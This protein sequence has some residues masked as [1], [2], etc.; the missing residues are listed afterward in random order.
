M[1]NYE[2]I[3]EALHNDTLD[4]VTPSDIIDVL[5]DADDLYYNGEESFLTDSEYDALYRYAERVVPH[6]VYFTGIGSE[7]RGGKIK[8]PYPM[9][10]LDQVYE[11]EIVD[12]V[13]GKNLLNRDHII[14]DKLDGNSA[15]LVFGTNGSIQIGY[16]RGDGIEGA[17]ITRHVRQ[18][19]SIPSNVGRQ[20]VVRGEMIIEKARF[21]EM[22]TIAL[23][24]AGRP[25]KN[26]RN[27][28]A[29]IMNAKT[30]NA[31]VYS[32]IDF[33]AY[34]IV[35]MDGILDKVEQLEQLEKLGFKVPFFSEVRGYDLT[36]SFLTS[37][38]TKR[39]DGN[40]YEIDGIVIDVN[41]AVGRKM[42]NP[43]RDTLNPAYA[44]K[45][46]I[47]DEN[48]QAVATVVNVEWN[49]S[50][51]CYL[52]P[53]VEI[54]PVE[55]VGVT[56]RHATGF[57]AKFIVDNCIGP[58]AKVLI[59]RSGDVIPF[60]QKVVEPAAEP[61]MPTVECSWNETR[62]DLVADEET[63]D[64]RINRLIDFFT[65]LDVPMLRE[66]N[67]RML[68]EAGYT[69]TESIIRMSRHELDNLIGSNGKKIYDGLRE[70][71][72]NVPR[73]VLMGSTHF[74]GRGVG[75]RKFKKLLQSIK[76]VTPNTVH[77]ITSVEGFDEKTAKKIAAGV[78]SFNNWFDMVKDYV[79]IS[80][81]E[82]TNDG[83]SLSGEKVVFTGFRDKDLEAAVEAAGGMIQSGVSSKT[84]I[85]V[86]VDPDSN[87]GKIKKARDL[88]IKIM[89]V[90]EFKELV[91]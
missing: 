12:W 29:G 83:G 16:S 91:K 32:F 79:T 42:L 70:K 43:T 45:Y 24:R 21:P 56:I 76:D 11:G 61:Q 2:A 39:R 82:V 18:I 72:T 19:P 64:I 73:Y 4:Q 74:F 23:N 59:T 58:G 77:L 17:D 47:A 25:Y 27:A 57:N 88:G 22:Q 44:V 3:V 40:I 13:A 37:Y 1:S 50:K 46:K 33:V 9:G 87:S 7:V 90:D 54:E 52:K 28:V 38:L 67:I 5:I 75:K 36:D 34:E 85:V 53:R 66:G 89:G 69:T 26:P 35:G 51:D 14:T 15:L 20:L 68:Y 8:L 84:T 63:D 81:E 41:D 65:S 60:I 31:D 6:A 80:Q 48:N 78:D 86:T 49:A 30:N 62:V 71:L 10:S 55:L